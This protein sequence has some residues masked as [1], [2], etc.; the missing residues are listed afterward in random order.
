MVI[1][2]LK[3][4]ALYNVICFSIMIYAYKV[5]R[6][7][8]YSYHGIDSFCGWLAEFGVVVM[9]IAAVAK[10]RIVVGGTVIGYIVGFAIFL[11]C[12]RINPLI[13]YYEN[14]YMIWSNIYILVILLSLAIAIIRGILK[15]KRTRVG[16]PRPTIKD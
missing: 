1:K 5:I 13:R 3:S 2:I 8:L 6:Y 9:V 11:L 7:D 10:S 12:I 16:N 15:R 14:S 4:N